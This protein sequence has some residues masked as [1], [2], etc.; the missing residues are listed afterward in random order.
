MADGRQRRWH[1][2]MPRAR[3]L[4]VT[5]LMVIREVNEQFADAVRLRGAA[6]G[7]H[8][9]PDEA[10]PRPVPRLMSAG[11]SVQTKT[12]F[13]C[14]CIAE[15]LSLYETERLIQELAKFRIDTRNIVV[16][17]LIFPRKGAVTAAWVMA[18]SG[19]RSRVPSS[20]LRRARSLRRPIARLDVRLLH[21]ALPHAV[22]VPQ[23]H[24]GSV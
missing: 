21:D 23:R 2:G 1:G 16:N 6:Q 22:Q 5:A 10:S 14:V 15:F 9:V 24:Q 17:Q 12:T 13:V 8:G 11:A 7:R 3:A 4:Q 20:A 18:A 19:R